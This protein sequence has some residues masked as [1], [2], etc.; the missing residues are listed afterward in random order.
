MKKTI[1]LLGFII[2][3]GGCA[4]GAFAPQTSL[5]QRNMDHNRS[6]INDYNSRAQ[7]CFNNLRDANTNE[8]LAK[9]VAIVDNEVFFVSDAS[10]N[11][12]ILMASTSNI[13]EIQAKALL[14]AITAGQECRVIK[15]QAFVM[16]PE[17]GIAFNNWIGEMDIVYANLLSK[18][19][20]IGQAN[21]EKTKLN[22]KLQSENASAIASMNNQFGKQIN[23]ENQ[24]Q[25]DN[26]QRYA[27][28]AQFILNQ[29]AIYQ[30]Q[31]NNQ[32]L[33]K[34]VITNCNRSW[35]GSQINC[36]TY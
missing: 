9:Q 14:E 1:I 7:T 23:Y 26:M 28:A 2:A 22:L 3:L 31:I 12:I 33:N 8:N 4:G 6:W 11:K 15:K 21:Q 32:I 19:I 27:V 35:S 34:P 29:Q 13:T 25:R 30:N 20:T 17:L 36:I 18:M 5:A 24:I 10:P 16:S